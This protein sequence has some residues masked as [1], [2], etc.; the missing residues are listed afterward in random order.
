MKFV[1]KRLLAPKTIKKNVK[2]EVLEIEMHTK[3][4]IGNRNST[5]YFNNEIQAKVQAIIYLISGH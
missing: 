4:R 1:N 3:V 5:R 2:E